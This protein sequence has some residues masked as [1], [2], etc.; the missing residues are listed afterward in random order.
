MKSWEPKRKHPTA[1]PT[2]LQ[3][4]VVWSQ[5]LKRS[6]KSH[7]T[8]PSTKCYFNEVLFMQ[9]LTHD[10]IKPTNCC[11][12]SACHGLPISC[13]A[14]LQEMGF[15]NNPSVH[16]TLS[17]RCHVGN[18]VDFTSILHSHI[19]SIGPLKRSVKANSD[20]LRLFHQWERLKWNGHGLS[21]PCVKWPPKPF[22]NSVRDTKYRNRWGRYFNLKKP[23][24]PHYP[25]HQCGP[26]VLG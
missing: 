2:H 23:Q 16:D 5:T 20:R 22:T 10:Q 7:V 12:H 26:W 1:I 21:V 17:I 6:V 15:A 13:Q 25:A 11:E 8:G 18:H 19:Y 14:Y 3:N 4:H 24:V 9:V